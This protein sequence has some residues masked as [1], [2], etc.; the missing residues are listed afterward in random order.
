MFSV[1]DQFPLSVCGNGVVLET[2]GTVQFLLALFA[3]FVIHAT[4][5]ASRGRLVINGKTTL[6]G[7]VAKTVA[8]IALRNRFTL[9]K[10]GWT[11][12]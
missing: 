5:S 9:S 1:V 3:V 8:S 12:V 4:P 10:L 11:P 7:F 6:V 2:I